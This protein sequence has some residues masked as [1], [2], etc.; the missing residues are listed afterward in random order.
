M[1]GKLLVAKVM[2]AE[3]KLPEE[4]QIRQALGQIR[5]DAGPLELTRAEGDSLVF[6]FGGETAAVSLVAEPMRSEEIGLAAAAADWYWPTAAPSLA[7]CH[8]QILVGVLP[9]LGERVE[10]ALR[11]TMLAAAVAE[12]AQAEA[13]L[14]T[15]AGLA[16]ASD[17]FAT[18]ARQMSRQD[19]PLYLWIDFHVHAEAD[20][21]SALY[22]TGLTAFQSPEIEV[23]GSRQEPRALVTRVYDIVHYLL[24]KGA[25]LHEGDTIGRSGEEK[26]EIHLG[27]SHR[28]LAARVVQLGL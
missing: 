18:Y 19:L 27:P 14:W 28:D 24:V 5:P 6:Q 2:L 1:A 11:L 20:G 10:S 26:I 3:T 12:A 15:A 7:R 8:G 25:V 9:D 13:V 22:T 17:A 16:H 23:Y 21:T 4:S